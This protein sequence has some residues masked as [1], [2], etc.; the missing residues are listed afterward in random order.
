MRT[1]RN[2]MAVLMM[3][4]VFVLYQG[5]ADAQTRRG[6]TRSTG[7]TSSATRSSSVNRSS[8]SSVNRQ[9]AA[10]PSG[11]SRQPS[12]QSRPSTQTKPSIQTKPS[13]QTKPSA[14]TRP[15]A[16]PRPSVQPRPSTQSKP[17]VQTRPS[18]QTRP[19]AQTRPSTGAEN[20]RPQSGA[21]VDRKPSNTV[22]SPGDR[23]TVNRPGSRPGDRK[24]S[25]GPAMKPDKPSPRPGAGTTFKPDRDRTPVKVYPNQRHDRPRVHPVKR[26]FIT[27][28]RPSS[29][30]NHHSHHYF[31]YRVRVLPARATIFRHHGIAYYCYNDIWYRPYGSYYVIC[32]PPFGTVLAA[33]LI[34]DLAWTAVRFSYYNT[35]FSTYSQINENNSYIAEQNE[36]IAKN[37]AII[38][39]Q[40]QTI[41]MNQAQAAASVTAA[42]ELG[43]V[44]SYAAA[45]GEYFYQDGVFYAKDKSGEYKVIVPPAGALVE[46]LPDDYEMVTLDGTE[47]YKV[48]NTVYKVV[49]SEGKPVFEVM[50]QLIS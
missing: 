15:S 47:Y 31:G 1:I 50:G 10:K 35:V 20:N 13:T 32:R 42:N 29:F 21:A 9:P 3:G 22:K 33:N 12:V 45:D 38:A 48:D 8:S 23:I 40:N 4:S 49:L 34:H 37:N 18:T 19:S 39:A 25:S 11:Q 28:D 43:L 16:Q 24:P 41:A 27:Y 36:I 2:I 46:S 7:T 5:D 6:D 17:S 30:W 44:Q 26:D 14:Q